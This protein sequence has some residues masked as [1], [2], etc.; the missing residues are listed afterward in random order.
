MASERILHGLIQ[1]AALAVQRQAAL[2][3][4]IDDEGRVWRR[5]DAGWVWTPQIIG[6]V[7]DRV[8]FLMGELPTPED[9]F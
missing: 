2:R 8:D 5:Q 1:C 6:S 4:R 7:D 9:H 3:V